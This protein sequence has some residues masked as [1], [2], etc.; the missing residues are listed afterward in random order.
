MNKEDIRAQL[1][2]CTRNELIV[3]IERSGFGYDVEAALIAVQ[4][5]RVKVWMKE[6]SRLSG[7]RDAAFGVSKNILKPYEGVP[8]KDVPKEIVR[9][10][11]EAWKEYC[12][13]KDEEIKCTKKINKLLFREAKGG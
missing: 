13:L 8:V 11:D 5:Q 10:A 4:A 6:E 3:I 7:L 12:R 9:Q 1:K 2:Q